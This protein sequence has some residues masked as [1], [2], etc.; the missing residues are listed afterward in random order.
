MSIADSTANDK[1]VAETAKPHR[2]YLAIHY[3]DKGTGT[4]VDQSVELPRA[5]A[6]RTVADASNRLTRALQ[7][8]LE[9]AAEHAD[10]TVTLAFLRQ[11]QP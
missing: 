3:T 7:H 4:L 6:V 9:N 11:V 5:G 10:A 1:P 2:L 8:V